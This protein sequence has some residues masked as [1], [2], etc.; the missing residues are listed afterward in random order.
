LSFLNIFCENIVIKYLFF[1][2]FQDKI[3]VVSGI[4]K[5][6]S[7]FDL[8]IGWLP[9]SGATPKKVRKSSFFGNR[10]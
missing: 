10:P 4:F 9:K 8:K 5:T 7:G 1:T 2:I 6:K 3:G